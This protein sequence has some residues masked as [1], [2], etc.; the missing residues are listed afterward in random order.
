M[1]DMKDWIKAGKITREVIEF[2]KEVVRPGIRLF[3][4]AEKIEAKIREL[5][6][7]IGFPVNISLNNI[8]AHYT[9]VPDDELAFEDQ[10]V[11]VDVGVC[12][13]GAIGDSAHTIDLS[14]KYS[15]LVKASREAL[16]AAEK[17]LGEGTTLGDI[18]KTIQETINS[19][20]FTTIKNLSGHGLD[21]YKVHSPP[22]IPNYNTGDSTEL[23]KGMIFAMEPFATDGAGIVQD[24]GEAMIFSQTASR[25]VRDPAAR[26][27]MSEITKLNGLPFCTRHFS[28]YGARLKLA[29]RS[30]KLAGNITDYAPL[31]EIKHGMVSQAENSFY[32]DDDGNAVNLTGM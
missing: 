5:G 28:H 23:K 15:D 13:N 21:R 11:K 24:S 32:I 9:P 4:A 29:L 1:E 26:K 17:I 19:Y 10:V 30:L 3:D 2:S 8:A 16:N 20:G 18:G 27:L 12:Y 31:G 14:G 6:G 22:Q 25:P 7:G